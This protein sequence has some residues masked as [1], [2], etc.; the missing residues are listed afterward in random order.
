MKPFRLP[1]LPYPAD[2][3]EPHIS[4][5]TLETHH[6]HHHKTYVEKL[7]AE[8]R[9]T[10]RADWSLERIVRRSSGPL[11]N[12]AA[13]AWNHEFFWHSLRP[14][15]G[16]RPAARL[17]EAI[18]ASFGNVAGLREEFTEAGMEH[19]GSGW[20]WLVA[21]PS[22]DLSI[23]TTHDA[24]TPLAGDTLPLL[25]CDLWE[26][27]WYL[28]RRHDKA[29]WLRAFWQVANWSFAAENLE[30]GT[31]YVSVATPAHVATDG[32]ADDDGLSAAHGNGSNGTRSAA[33]ARPT[34]S[35]PRRTGHE[36]GR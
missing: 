32:G 6:G 3:L 2:A 10:P 16:P 8:V 25:T 22:G 26:H 21:G 13:Q 36:A 9:G 31:P 27:A 35:A 33:R 5:L 29:A 15:G 14:A 1:P 12:N 24:G 7:N 19:F 23:L 34:R 28:D 30:R 17:A 20:A 4:R 18:G 11:F